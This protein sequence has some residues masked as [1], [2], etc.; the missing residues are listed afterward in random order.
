VPSGL[1]ILTL[2]H[3]RLALHGMLDAGHEWFAT[4]PIVV[5]LWNGIVIRT[6]SCDAAMNLNWFK[7]IITD[8]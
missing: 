7:T 5:E 2:F 1:P 8:Q 6:V 4:T 3:S